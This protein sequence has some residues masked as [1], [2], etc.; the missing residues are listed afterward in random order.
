MY[1][2]QY[3]CPRQSPDWQD[4][5]EPFLLIFRTP[6]TFRTFTEAQRACNTLLWQFHAARVLDPAGRPIYQ[7]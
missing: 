6:S 7:V 4:L 3:Y 5:T 2:V 1:R